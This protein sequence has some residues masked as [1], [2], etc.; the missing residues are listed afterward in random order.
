[1][2]PVICGVDGWDS[3]SGSARAVHVA[4]QL[5]ARFERPLLFV[6]VVHTKD[7]EEKVDG[8]TALL[9]HAAETS[10]GIE[11][12]WAVE[13]GHPADQLV[14]LAR[15]RDASLVVVGSHG[16]R[17]SLLGSISADVSR[18]APC[19]VVVVP[20]PVDEPIPRHEHGPAAVRRRRRSTVR[21]SAASDAG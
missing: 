1:M 13:A 21:L 3:K 12:A 16:P 14:A 17:S 20:P 2:R 15:E 11:A 7:N 6:T 5:A 4:R 8:A 18:R 9:K 19:P 10:N